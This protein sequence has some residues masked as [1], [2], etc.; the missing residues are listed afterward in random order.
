MLKCHDSVAADEFQHTN[1]ESIIRFFIPLHCIIAGSSHADA[2]LCVVQQIQ[3]FIYIISD[4]FSRFFPF[5]LLFLKFKYQ[6][7]ICTHW[8]RSRSCFSIDKLSTEASLA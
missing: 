7:E 8:N 3:R 4:L 1:A 2:C 5:C 6:M